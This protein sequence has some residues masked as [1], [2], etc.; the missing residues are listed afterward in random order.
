ARLRG[1]RVAT[2]VS[3]EDKAAFVR[4]LGAEQPIFYRSEDFVDRAKDWTA[5]AGLD[6]ALDNVGAE[7]MQ[8]M[9]RAMAPY[10]R[11]V[12]LMGTPPDDPDQTA[13][14]MNLTIHNVMMLTPMLLGRRD[15][16]DAQARRVERGM[17]LLASGRLQLHVSEVFALA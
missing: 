6:V 12:T 8:R 2:T 10:G 5:G 4:Q 17:E 3:T 9:F 16:L 15:L 14:V 13:Y 1:G 11:I 7:Q